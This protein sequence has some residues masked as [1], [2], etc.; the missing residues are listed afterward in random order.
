MKA[1]TRRV[2]EMC[3]RVLNWTLEHPDDEPGFVVLTAQ[4]Q[5]LVE[6]IGQLIT[7]QREGLVDVRAGAERKQE[8][9]YTI[10]TLSIAHLARIGARAARERHELSE[11]FRYKLENNSY[12]TFQTAARMMFAEALANKE[13]LVRYGLSESVLNELGTM[14]DEFDA[15]VRLGVN[16]RAAHTSATMAMSG[17]VREAREIVAAMDARNRIRFRDHYQML[18]EWNSVRK[19][20]GTP[21]G[22]P[23]GG[24]SGSPEPGADVRP[25]A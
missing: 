2:F 23:E 1:A 11:T 17:M 5:A 3:L 12:V 10:L 21:R 18:A 7:E 14:L 4:L 13:L 25:A 20:L 19:V 9:R 16:G 8:L 6:R 24:E 15:A 22:R